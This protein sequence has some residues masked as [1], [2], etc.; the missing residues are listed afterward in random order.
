MNNETQDFKTDFNEL[1]GLGDWGSAI[2]GDTISLENETPE[3]G[4][5]E[6]KEEETSDETETV[7]EEEKEEET[8]DDT[9]TGEKKE[10][11]APEDKELSVSSGDNNLSLDEKTSLSYTEKG[12]TFEVN[13]S[14]VLDKAVKANELENKSISF[15]SEKKALSKELESTKTKLTEQTDKIKK[16]LLSENGSL[17]DIVQGLSDVSGGLSGRAVLGIIL[18]RIYKT[19]NL[20][21]FLN[22]GGDNQADVAK[23]F[24]G[25]TEDI[26]SFHK[27]SEKEETDSRSKELDEKSN[28]LSLR[29]KHNLSQDELSDYDRY[30]KS[31]D[32]TVEKNQE[33]FNKFISNISVVKRGTELL[34]KYFPEAFEKHADYVN[35]VLKYWSEKGIDEKSTIAYL[36]EKRIE[37]GHAKKTSDK[38][39]QVKKQNG[40]D[41]SVN[42]FFSGGS[43]VFGS[44]I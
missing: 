3:E 18:D 30:F 20:K 40:F 11:E 16:S 41:N 24:A 14:E 39:K 26:K 36:K 32:S 37:A 15:E 42:P 44:P 1:D 22:F 12:E 31:A 25:A 43:D 34:D 27:S 28:M 23:I 19:S 33:N 6:K 2:P 17:D 8:S 21:R 10:E 9:E 13:L 35:E 38:K 5:E 4:G 29:E 7:D